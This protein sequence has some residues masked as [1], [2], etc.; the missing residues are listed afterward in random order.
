MAH[1]LE[2]FNKIVTSPDDVVIS[3][4]AVNAL[5]ESLMAVVSPGRD[6]PDS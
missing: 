3:C 5:L 6:H 4:G 1:K 2:R